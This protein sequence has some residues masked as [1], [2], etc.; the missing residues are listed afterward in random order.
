MWRFPE[1][2][3]VGWGSGARETGAGIGQPPG[4]RPKKTAV[5]ALAGGLFGGSRA[6]GAPTWKR[7]ADLERFKISGGLV[8]CANACEDGRRRGVGLP[9]GR[10]FVLVG[11]G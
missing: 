7:L 1:S 2:A 10:V 9:A 5:F 4:V 11:A 8:A 6:E 3:R